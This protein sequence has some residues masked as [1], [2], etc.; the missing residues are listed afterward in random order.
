MFRVSPARSVQSNPNLKELKLTNCG[1]HNSGIC[2]LSEA[3]AQHANLK[4]VELERSQLAVSGATSLAEAVKVNV[5]IE[6]LS[7]IGCD[8]MKAEGATKV[9][10]SMKAN[11]T[12]KS[13]FLPDTFR[14]VVSTM[15]TKCQQLKGRVQCFEDVV[16]QKVVDLSNKQ[17]NIR[18]LG[19]Y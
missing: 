19:E 16:T 14:E 18:S 11:K 9:L 1:V 8:D 5:S 10:E 17:I 6:T 3:F 13:L 7:L 4:T 15:S 2:N 12:L